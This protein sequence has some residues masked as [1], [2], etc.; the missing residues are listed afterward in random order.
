MVAGSPGCGVPRVAGLRVLRGLRGCGVCIGLR[1]CGVA[2]L[3]VRT[4][5]DEGFIAVHA[6]EEVRGVERVHVHHVQQPGV[7]IR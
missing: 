2:W 6:R 7:G 5:D 3:R 4:L 1:G